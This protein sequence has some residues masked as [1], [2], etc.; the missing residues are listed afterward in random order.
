M[1]LPTWRRQDKEGNWIKGS[2][3]DLAE[4]EKGENITAIECIAMA[5]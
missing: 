2:Y 5:G 4:S 3:P 1:R